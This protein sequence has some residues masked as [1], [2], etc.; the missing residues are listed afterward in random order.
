[1]RT[2]SRPSRTPEAQDVTARVQT[3]EAGLRLARRVRYWAASAAVGVA[4][5]LAALTA[6]AYHARAASPRAVGAVSG[7]R[8]VDDGAGSTESTAP[9]ALHP[10]AAPPSPAP[11]APVAPVV[12]GGS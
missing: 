12:S 11:A 9:A 2:R 6:H 4:G 5:G 10:P 8:P 1:M 3:R 7:Q